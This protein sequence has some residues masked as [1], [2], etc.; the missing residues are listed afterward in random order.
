MTKSQYLCP[1]CKEPLSVDRCV[2]EDGDWMLYCAYYG[3]VCLKRPGG[4]AANEG[5]FGPT[6]KQAYA[7]LVRAVEWEQDSA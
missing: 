3:S 4:N 1:V 6:E 7:E 5:G 2:R